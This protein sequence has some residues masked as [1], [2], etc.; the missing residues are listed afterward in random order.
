MYLIDTNIFL[1]ILLD[2]KRAS[3]C[4]AFLERVRDGSV[5]GYVTSFSIHSIEVILDRFKKLDVLEMFLEDL[6]MFTS[7]E[8]INTHISDEVKIVKSISK[9]G[10]DFD[11]SLQYYVAKKKAL[12]LV[13]FDEDFDKTDLQRIDPAQIIG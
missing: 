3:D 8:V 4:V 9:I 11:D 10:L 13:S 12:Q 7:L 1:E 2:Q 6:S 5:Q